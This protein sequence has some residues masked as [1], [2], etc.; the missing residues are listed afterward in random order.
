MI[1]VEALNGLGVSLSVNS[2]SSYQVQ[3]IGNHLTIA[4]IS[5]QLVVILIFVGLSGLFHWRCKNTTV[6]IKAVSKMLWVLYGSMFLIFARCIYRLVEHTGGTKKDLDNLEALRKLS[7]ILRYESFF[8]V[9]EAT[10]MLVNSVLWNIWNPGRFLPKNY[11][12]YLGPDGNEIE[13]EEQADNRPF[14][15]KVVN[16]IS[17]GVLYSKKRQTGEFQELVNLGGDGK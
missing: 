6:Q 2:S 11:N 12:V 8:Y 7:P 1:L 15:A 13:G 4:A 16:I 5:L 17:F 3:A 14:W 9:F 10:L